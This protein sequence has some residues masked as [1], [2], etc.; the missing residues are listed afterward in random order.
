M[1][2]RLFKR[3]RYPFPTLV[4]EHAAAMQE[5]TERHWIDG[6]CRGFVAPDIAEG[7]KRARTA[8]MTSYFFPMA[9]WER[10]LPLARMMVFSIYQDD[11]YE[12]AS[13]EQVRRIREGTVSVA[14]GERMPEETGV[15][16]AGL[17]AGV[18][19][20]AL[21]FIPE[22]AVQR[23]ADDVDLY[24]EGLEEET[25]YV[26]TGRFPTI[27][28]YQVFRERALMLHPFMSLKEV[29]TGVVLPPEVHAHS[30]VQRLKS[31]AVR[32]IGRFNEFQS[33]DKDIKTG[34]GNVNLIGVVAHD[35][36]IGIQEASEYAL[37]LHDEELAEFVELQHGLPEFDGWHDAVANHIHHISFVISGWR[38]VDSK[39]DRYDP[40]FYLDQDRLRTSVHVPDRNPH[41]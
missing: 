21:R 38:G 18:R 11:I 14:R 8:Y 17:I 2:P 13:P 15:M 16:L 34:M 26:R 27:E 41:T 24:F 3:L 19:A 35:R 29:E 22:D 4:N 9:T 28:R 25:Y 12:K 32:V 31:L 1:E 23:W 39:I 6:E 10:L 7:F 30:T 36:D 37:R 40:E 5:H 20:G 33:Y